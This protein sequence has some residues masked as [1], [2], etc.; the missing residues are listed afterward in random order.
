MVGEASG[1]LQEIGMSAVQQR[2][3]LSCPSL[4]RVSRSS[5]PA[6][7]KRGR[8]FSCGAR[9]A[10]NAPRTEKIRAP[11]RGALLSSPPAKRPLS[12]SHQRDT[13]Q[14]VAT[15]V[16]LVGPLDDPRTEPSISE[17]ARFVG[18]TKP[19]PDKRLLRQ[20]LF[21]NSDGYYQTLVSCEKKLPRKKSSTKLTYKFSKLFLSDLVC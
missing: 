21:N 20:L 8:G 4:R 18:R 7:R 14:V 17:C 6:L 11:C 5:S 1:W 2:A 10:L 13:L 19:T 15:G 12:L 9:G 3:F 16:T